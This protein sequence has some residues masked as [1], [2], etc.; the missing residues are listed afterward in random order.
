MCRINWVSLARASIVIPT[1]VGIKVH[2]KTHGFPLKA[3][4]NDMLRI[5]EFNNIT[6]LNLLFHPFLDGK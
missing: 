6:G 1:Q 3:C 4:G 2:S 5:G